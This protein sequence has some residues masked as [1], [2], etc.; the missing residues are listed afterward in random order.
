MQGQ[1]SN[2]VVVPKNSR[3]QKSENQSLT[4]EATGFA[5]GVPERSPPPNTNKF[6][7]L[8]AESQRLEHPVIV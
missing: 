4:P 3:Y 5:S 7:E 1:R 2:S 8:V 6:E